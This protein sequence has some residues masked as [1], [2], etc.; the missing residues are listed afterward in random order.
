MKERRVIDE[1]YGFYFF[2]VSFLEDIFSRT[3]KS[4]SIYT[5]KVNHEIVNLQNAGNR[6]AK[7]VVLLRKIAKK[8]SKVLW[9]LK[10]LL[11]NKIVWLIEKIS[12]WDAQW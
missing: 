6:I 3:L 12:C 5:T 8:Q 1:N 2:L 9:I 7:K 4:A 11:L 10:L